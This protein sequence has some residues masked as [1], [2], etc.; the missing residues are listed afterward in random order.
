MNYAELSAI[1]DEI[2]FD[3]SIDDGFRHLELRVGAEN[4][5]STADQS[6]WL[7]VRSTAL[8]GHPAGGRKWRISQHM[9]KSEVVQTALKAVI[10]W[11]EHETREA[12]LYK[13]VAV[14]GPHLDVEALVCIVQDRCFDVREP[15]PA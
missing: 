14:F 6:Y 10:A 1:V 15:V 8:P 3:T 7:Q 9:T 4:A 13:N 12:F 2:H 5:A 11:W